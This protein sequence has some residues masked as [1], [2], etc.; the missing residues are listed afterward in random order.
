MRYLAPCLLLGAGVWVWYA[1]LGDPDRVMVLWGTHL[2]PGYEGD[3][4]AQGQLAW[5]VLL[6]LGSMLLG[7]QVARDLRGRSKEGS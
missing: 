3:R 5:Q 6:G 4:V 1:N 7:F 2:V